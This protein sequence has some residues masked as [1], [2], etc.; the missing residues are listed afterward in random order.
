MN[1]PPRSIEYYVTPDGAVPFGQWLALLRDP[2]CQASILVRLR[3]ASVAKNLPQ[4]GRGEGLCVLPCS[5][6]PEVR[7]YCGVDGGGLVVLR[8]GERWSRRRDRH[9]IGQYWRDCR[10]RRGS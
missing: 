9:L 2:Q 3:E 10:R 7:V 6:Y 8:G 4:S 5:G 1:R